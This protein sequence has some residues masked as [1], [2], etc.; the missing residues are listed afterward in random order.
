MNHRTRRPRAVFTA[1][2]TLALCGAGASARAQNGATLESVELYGNLN[3]VGVAATIS[4]DDNG[5]ST[6]TLTYAAVG[7]GTVYPGHPLVRLD[8]LRFAGSVFYLE[9]GTEY[10]VTV[11][12][13]DPDNP[14]D[15]V[16]TARI[17]TRADAPPTPTGG[18]LWVDAE[19]GLDTNPGT[20]SQPLAT[21]QAA[22]DLA[23]PGD[24]VRLAPGIYYEHVDL[25]R[26]GA[27]DNP[28]VI[29]GEPGAILSGAD[30]H[31]AESGP[32]WTAEGNDIYSTPF[33]GNCWY[34]AADDVRIYDYQ[35]LTELQ[36]ESGKMGVPGA[37]PGGFYV[38]AGAGLLHLRLPDRSNPADHVI[39]ATIRD[40]GILIDTITD[41]VIE[42]LEIR[43]FGEV[44]VDVR[45]SRRSWV[46]R[47]HLH[48]V[49]AGVR[50]RRPESHDN[51]VEDNR[52][53][54]TSVYFWP[55]DSCKAETCEASGVSV[56]GGEGNVVRRNTIEGFFNGVYTGEWDTTDESI[57]RNTDVTENTLFQIGDDGLEPE[58]ACVN[59]RFVENTI[60]EVYNAI[61]LAPIDTGPTWLVR[62]VVVGFKAHVLKLNNASTGYMFAYHNT[63]VPHPDEDGA[64]PLSPSVP[65]GGLVARNNIWTSNRYVIEYGDTSL[66]GVVDLDYDDLWTHDV[67]GVG[68]FVKWLDVRYADLAELQT[69]TGLELH[70]LQTEP[71]YEDA[72]GGNFTPVEGSPLLDVGLPIP[73]INDRFSVDGPDI[74][75]FERG[76][77]QPGPDDGG[78]PW[79]DGGGAPWPDAGTPSGDGGTTPPGDNDSGCGCRNSAGATPAWPLLILLSWLTLRRRRRSR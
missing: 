22:V 72:A 36:E 5:D 15:E 64:Q 41:V 32:V 42:G 27:A 47:N 75:A 58:G 67:E 44:A 51:V 48:H 9:A 61:S 18:E 59:H 34:L 10:D 68:R 12:V 24:T 69:G 4:G 50:L 19:S 17:T 70:G 14:A 23:Q 35:S 16:Q 76:G 30:Q 65:F 3:T 6:A 40:V 13:S 78:V 77:I 39:Y 60:V 66:L 1:V 38:D 28:L 31:L 73:G 52:L 11:V 8:G 57:A 56:T 62:N 43:H 49:N 20:Q 37:L 53:R 79:P 46:R 45:D 54:D 26:G 63:S 74:G 21:I 2:A 25:P 29:L 7:S 71:V 33:T 55:W